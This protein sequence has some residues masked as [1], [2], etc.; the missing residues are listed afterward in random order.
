[1]LKITAFLHFA[2]LWPWK[3]YTGKKPGAEMSCLCVCTKR[4]FVSDNEPKACTVGIYST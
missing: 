4:V 1:M 3:K 2:K